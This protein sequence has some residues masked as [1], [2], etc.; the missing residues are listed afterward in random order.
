MSWPVGLVN[1]DACVSDPTLD[2]I[3]IPNRKLISISSIAPL[4]PQ[5][6][7]NYIEHWRG[8]IYDEGTNDLQDIMK[9]R[10]LKR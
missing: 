5:A 2:D 10:N 7:D 3:A 8:V 4:N 9:E 1:H 6:K